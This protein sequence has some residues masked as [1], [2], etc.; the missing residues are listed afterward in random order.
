MNQFRAGRPSGPDQEATSG[1]ATTAVLR[2]ANLAAVLAEL[3]YGAGLAR[4]QLATRTG[5]TTATVTRLTGT[6]LQKGVLVE[7]AAVPSGSP[8]RP[9]VP[10]RISGDYVVIAVHIGALSTRLGVVDL[11]GRVSHTEHSPHRDSSAERELPQ[12]IAAVRA[13][14]AR[15]PQ[16]VIGIGVSTGGW[17]NHQSGRII[18]HPTM[19]WRDVPVT[20][21]LEHATGLPTRVAANEF[22]GVLAERLF[23]NSPHVENLVYLFVGNV[24]AMAA[25]SHGRIVQGAH[26][27][28]GV[29][30][31]LSVGEETA[32]RCRCGRM[33]CLNAATSQMAVVADATEAGL[34]APHDTDPMDHLL[35]AADDGNAAAAALL[36]QRAHRVG[37]A[38][39]RLIELFDPEILVVGGTLD[40]PTYLTDIWAGVEEALDSRVTRDVQTLVRAPSFGNQ[41][42]TVSPAAVLLDDFYRDP[43]DYIDL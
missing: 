40:T 34:L 16:T 30:D 7:D 5:L 1:Y 28:A 31:H 17:V 13:L 9:L 33:D 42:F 21:E 37:R 27:A 11:L 26:H 38:A 3:R 23:G 41:E 29:V 2:R 32:H 25:L 14:I 19:D 22:A 39:A 36:H 15:I 24:V 43:V 20:G 6:L 35:E 4:S 8:G 12:I 18:E 10:V